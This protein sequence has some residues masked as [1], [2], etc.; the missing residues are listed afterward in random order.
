M[1]SGNDE[2]DDDGD[3]DEPCP[4]C[5]VPLPDDLDYCPHCGGRVAPPD[6]HAVFTEFFDSGLQ[7]AT[8]LRVMGIVAMVM[9]TL[10]LFVPVFP[11][12]AKELIGGEMTILGVLCL[13]FHTREYRC[14]RCGTP[15][16]LQDAFR[17]DAQMLLCHNCYARLR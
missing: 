8:A 16:D 10:L 12:A 13:F 15:V 6:P 3:G 14:P 2:A 9:G 4:Y 1:D 11:G 17:D 5:Y 7:R